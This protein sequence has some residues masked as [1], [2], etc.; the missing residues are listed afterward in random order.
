LVIEERDK[1]GRPC[2]RHAFNIQACEQ[3][4]AWIGGFESILMPMI[5]GN[6]NWFVHSMLFLSHSTYYCKAR[7]KKGQCRN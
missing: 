5:A 4:N 3:P 1:Q 2:W 6:F 7:K